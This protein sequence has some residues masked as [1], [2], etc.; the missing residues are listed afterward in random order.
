MSVRICYVLDAFSGDRNKDLSHAY[1]REMLECLTRMDQLYLQKHPETPLLYDSG[2]TYQEEPPGAEDW[3]DIPSIL[4]IGWGDCVP[5][6]TLVLRDDYSFAPIAALKPGDRIMGDGTWTSVL[7]GAITGEKSILAFDLDNGGVLRCS[8]EHRL[9]MRDGSERH[10][11]DVKVGERLKAPGSAFPTSETPWDFGAIEP[12]DF[13]WLVGTHI[14]DGWVD[15]HETRFSISGFDDRPKRGKVE[16]KQ[17]IKAICEKAGIN[18]RWAPKYIEVHDAALTEVMLACGKRAPNKHVPNLARFNSGQVRSLIEGLQT[19]CS[20]ANEGTLT[21]GTTS[22][23]LALQL[24]VLYRM[25]GQ[26]VHI[27]RWDEHGGLGTHPIYRVIV[28]RHATE[29]T[30]KA[31][32]TRAAFMA[33][34]VGVRAIRLEEEPELCADITT[35]SGRFY[36]PE[37]DLVVHN[38][39]EL[40][41][42]RV[43][44][45]RERYGINAQCEF[46]SQRKDDGSYLYHIYVKLPDGR[47]ED[48]SRE[49]GMI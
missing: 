42:W 49:L 41:A 7:E 43:A 25:C 22:E 18:A 5:L 35:D 17:R 21:H 4:K 14:A 45:L 48:P 39:E 28:R 13:A 10:A 6:S 30:T 37:T 9:F 1:L 16:Q 27:K 40:A 47:T 32:K 33:D 2:V 38:C 44:E 31:W 19:D 12:A 29:D 34:S 23:V 46:S 3:V 15:S 20:V 11:C 24:R 8:P 36:L 26:S